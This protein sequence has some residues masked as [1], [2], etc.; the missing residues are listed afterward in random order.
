MN[1]QATCLILHTALPAAR[2]L[3]AIRAIAR[4]LILCRYQSNTK[5]AAGVSRCN[6]RRFSL[7]D[8]EPVMSDT[9]RC[10]SVPSTFPR[11]FATASA[12]I[13]L[14]AF[15]AVRAALPFPFDLPFAFAF[16][17]DEDERVV[18]AFV[19]LAPPR[20]EA[21]TSSVARR[22]LFFRDAS[23]AEAHCPGTELW[24]DC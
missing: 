22:S 15:V 24:C 14:T 17:E 2:R 18:R 5:S 10:E 19:L 13:P 9:H 7:Q 3:C 23:G 12:M 11:A 20:P 1:E 16:A 4:M 21:W 6:T 8:R